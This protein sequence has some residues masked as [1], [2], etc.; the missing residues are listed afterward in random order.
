MLNAAQALTR[1]YAMLAPGNHILCAVSGGADS[2][3]LLHW[4][5]GRAAEDGFTLTAA[6]FDHR[7]RGAESDRDAAF[8]GVE[9]A[10][11][12]GA[13]RRRRGGPAAGDGHRGDR[14]GPA[15]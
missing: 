13:R 5:K 8:V 15:L 1:E 14:P 6:H 7:L 11:R 10:L 3:C 2:V 9:G 12:G 4:L